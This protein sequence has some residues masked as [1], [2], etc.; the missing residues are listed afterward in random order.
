VN[1]SSSHRCRNPASH[2]LGLLRRRADHAHA[3]ERAQ[4]CRDGQAEEHARDAPERRVDDA[5]CERWAGLGAV[6]A[7]EVL[8]DL[9][10][11]VHLHLCVRVDEVRKHQLATLCEHLSS[12]PAAF[13]CVCGVCA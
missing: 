6:C 10:R 12:V 3:R 9:V 7:P 1:K 13:V 8:D 5:I 4:D 2:L 11:V